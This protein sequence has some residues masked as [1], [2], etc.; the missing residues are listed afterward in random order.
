VSPSSELRKGDAVVFKSED[1]CQVM[2]LARQTAKK[3][4]LKPFNPALEDVTLERDEVEWMA[5]IVWVRH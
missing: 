1:G 5:R 3:V 2:K 4:D